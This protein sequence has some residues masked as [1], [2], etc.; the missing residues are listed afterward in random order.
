MRLRDW[1]ARFTARTKPQAQYDC[2][3]WAGPQVA[4]YAAGDL[5][6]EG[7]PLWVAARRLNLGA[8]LGRPFILTV[9]GPDGKPLTLRAQ[10]FALGIAVCDNAD[11][12]CIGVVSHFGT[13]EVAE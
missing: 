10:S 13:S 6:Q 12:R 3:A 9:R 8:P 11:R 7:D 4:R 5:W 1:L 2:P